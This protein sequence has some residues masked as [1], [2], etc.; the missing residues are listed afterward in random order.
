VVSEAL[1]II[2]IDGHRV[3]PDKVIRVY[4]G[5]ELNEYCPNASDRS[6]RH[7]RNE[8]GIGATDVLIGAIGRLVWQ[9]G[10]E[11]LIKSLPEI[12]NTHPDIKVIFVGDGPYR[13]SL[14]KLCRQSRVED[15]TIFT[16]YRS[17]IKRILSAI[18]IKVIPSLAEGFPMVTLEAMAM[19]KPIVATCIDGITEQITDGVEGILVPPRDP[20]AL[21]AAINAIIE[22]KDLARSLGSAARKRVEREFTV[23]QMIDETEKVYRSLLGLMNTFKPPEESCPYC[24]SAAEFDFSIHE[25]QYHQC[26]SCDL[27][28]KGNLQIEAEKDLVQYYE[29]GYFSE[30]ANDQLSGSRNFIYS[31]ILALMESETSVGKVLDVGCGCGFFLKE[32]RNRGWDVAGVDPSEE[33]IAYADKLLGSNIARKGTLEDLSQEKVYDVITMIDALGFSSAPWADVEKVKRL[34]KPGGLLFLRCSNGLLHSTLLKMS[35]K[36]KMDD[37]INNL[38]VF[39]KYPLTPRFIRRLL[40]DYGFSIVF[41]QNA[42]PSQGDFFN[43]LLKK[44][45]GMT[46]NALHFLSSGRIIIGPSV[47][48]IARKA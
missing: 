45:V 17:D 41:I 19:E 6:S 22:N 37:V 26:K 1:R 16:G 13:A 30:Y 20:N 46:V 44:A 27:I 21:A 36:L 28:F 39:H 7:I 43:R 34:L 4:N 18:D 23:E 33:S 12:A 47:E 38:L 32:A 35:I 42:M 11:Y 15:K 25:R 5:I 10:F 31:H 14:E 40:G 9:K 24:H 48:V 3:T 2:M 8:Y 29:H